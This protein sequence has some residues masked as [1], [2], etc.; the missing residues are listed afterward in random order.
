MPQKDKHLLFPGG[1]HGAFGQSKALFIH[2]V[3][4]VFLFCQK[5]C[6][7]AF[8]TVNYKLKYVYGE[9]DMK[10]QITMKDLAQHF[11]VSLNTVH[12]AI[13]GKPGI[14][15]ATRSRIVE[16]ANAHGYQMNT[17]AS[18]LKKKSITVA[19]CLPELDG[20]SRY[21]YED[22]WQGARSYLAERR[23]LKVKVLEFPYKQ[24]TLSKCLAKIRRMMEEENLQI[25]GLLTSPP[26][27]KKGIAVIH[28]MADK[29]VAVQ[30]V[31]GDNKSCP[32]LG[33]VMADYSAA[34]QIM[35]EQLCHLL[36]QHGRVLLMSGSPYIDAHQR[37]TEGF[38]SYV[39]ANAPGCTVEKLYGGY[40]MTQLHSHLTSRLKKQP[41]NAVCCIFGSGSVVLSRALRETGFAGKIPA[42]GNDV[43]EEN[44]EALKNGTFINLVYK[45]PRKQAR[46]A[47]QILCSH[48]LN[49][50]APA[51]NSSL[52]EIA[53]VF[54]SNVDYYLK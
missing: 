53:L 35:A 14:S 18:L 15:E 19:L 24:D 32:R 13:N 49:R 44:V 51:E 38:E 29:G 22:I 7:H 3:D 33:A 52:V 48:L 40:D 23:D 21:F 16:Y 2:A 6:I 17:A 10:S 43:F 8:F 25:D 20:T 50:S 37:L 39:K 54:K 9:N 31:I 45:N 34:G 36:P 12:K 47:M 26:E 5:R 27:D 28:A 46:I 1:E 42:I 4:S 41:P 11:G 30:F